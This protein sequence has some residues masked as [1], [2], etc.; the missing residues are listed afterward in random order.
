MTM[1]RYRHFFSMPVAGSFESDEEDFDRA[2]E[3]LHYDKSSKETVELMVSHADFFFSFDNI[4]PTDT[5][6]NP[7]VIDE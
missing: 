6:Q 2:L 7:E 1:P 4:Y 5:D 3:I